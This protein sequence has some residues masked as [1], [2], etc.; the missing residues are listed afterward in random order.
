MR[1]YSLYLF[2]TVILIHSCAS[3][4]AEQQTAALTFPELGS[5]I[6][7]RGALWYSTSEQVGLPQWSAPIKVQLQ[8]L[9]FNPLSYTAY[10]EYMANAGK[11]NSIAYR[12]SLPYKPKYIRLQLLDKIRLTNELNS[13]SNKQVMAYLEN[14]SD[15]KIVT[16]MDFTVPETIMPFFETADNVLLKQ[17]TFNKVQLVLVNGGK[18]EIIDFSQIQVFDFEY[19]SFCWGEDRYHKK[20]IENIVPVG[21][22]CPKGTYVKPEKVKTEKSYLKF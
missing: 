11:I 17:D 12:D 22:K 19:S 9:P 2:L 14:D 6:K 5:I 20:Q 18:E 1:K 7:T 4:K 15:C 13:E 8:Q 3:F 10:A 21:E 16:R